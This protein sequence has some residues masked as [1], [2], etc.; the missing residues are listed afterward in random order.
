MT[1]EAVLSGGCLCGA[2]RF[3]ATDVPTEA[4]VCHCEMCRRWSGG[5]GF[6]VIAEGLHFEG[7]EN[8]GLYQHGGNIRVTQH[9]ETSVLRPVPEQGINFGN[10]LQQD[11]R[12]VHA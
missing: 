11:I 2:V 3:T 10:F 6:A 4:S 8:I 7:A 5:P 12:T 1:D 9:F